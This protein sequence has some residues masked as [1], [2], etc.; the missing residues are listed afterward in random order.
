MR[1]HP[2]PW[3]DIRADKKQDA[4][5]QFYETFRKDLEKLE[6]HELTKIASLYRRTQIGANAQ[7]GS[8]FTVT[9]SK[10]ELIP[11]AVTVILTCPTLL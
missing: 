6:G 3:R 5:S 4:D 10:F 11:L 8:W 1:R 2:I 7:V 9:L